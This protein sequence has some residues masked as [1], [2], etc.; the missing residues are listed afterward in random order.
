M[1][2]VATMLAEMG[3]MYGLNT[4]SPRLTWWQL[5]LSARPA[6]VEP[7][8]RNH[9]PGGGAGRLITLEHLLH[10]RTALCPYWSR[11]LCWS[12]ICLSVCHSSAQTTR[13][14]LTE[15]ILYKLWHSIHYCFW[16]R[17]SLQKSGSEPMIMKSTT[18]TIFS[19]TLKQL[20]W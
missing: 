7:Q 13:H 12:W 11:Y 8:I 1:N 20:A 3:V 14:R 9:S 4:Y 19:T 6:N 18:L 15:C 17:T 10:G 16:Q 2:K 5:L